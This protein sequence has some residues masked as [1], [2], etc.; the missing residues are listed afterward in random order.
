MPG[1]ALV[2]CACGA[3]GGDPHLAQPRAPREPATASAASRAPW[4]RAEPSVVGSPAPSS[5]P[6]SPAPPSPPVLAPPEPAV[7]WRFRS[8][9]PLTG[10]PGVSPSGLVYLA[11]VEGYLHA[12]APDGSFRWSYGLG[13]MPV[14]APAVDPAGHVFVAT[15]APQ[16]QAFKPDGHRSWAV[17]V[18]ARFATPPVWAAPGIIYFAGRDRNLYSIAAWGSAPRTHWLGSTA[19][20]ALGSLADGAV[21]VVLAA[22]EA[23]VFRRASL[24]A[25]LDLAAPSE[26]ALLGGKAH[27][28]AVTRAGIVAFDVSTR[29][30]VWTAPARRAGLSADERAL[31][32]EIE[33]D[34]VWLE[35]ASGRELHRARLPEAA[36]SPPALTNSGIALVPL[37]SGGLLVIEPH[38]Q[39]LARLAL[40]A[41]PAWPPVWSEV[42]RRVIAAAGG[43]VAGIDLSGWVG[44]L[45]GGPRETDAPPSDASEPRPGD[46]ARPSLGSRPLDGASPQGG[47]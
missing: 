14:G 27:W 42:N 11:S 9:T 34:L 10:A 45:D 30:P 41:A 13:A 46:D 47:A 35:P 2:V 7:Q 6:P 24:L 31:V 28:F 19:A 17:G 38:T 5:A 12:L 29:A 23:Q 36:S 22:A 39:R 3:L 33:G 21:A 32:I 44:P 25:R 4:R 8:A 20:G 1:A 43:D 26:Q 18:P 15:T 16:L 40:G 37:V